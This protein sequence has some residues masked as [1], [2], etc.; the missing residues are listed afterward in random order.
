[1]TK[2]SVT[3]FLFFALG[4]VCIYSSRAYAFDFQYDMPQFRYGIHYTWNSGQWVEAARFTP[5]YNSSGQLDSALVEAY[6]NQNYIAY[7]RATETYVNGMISLYRISSFDGTSWSGLEVDSFTYSGNRILYQDRMFYK[8]GALQEH[9][10]YTHSYNGSGVRIERLQETLIPGPR[11]NDDDWVYVYDNQG[12]IDTLYDNNWD[13]AQWVR[14]AR[15]VYRY[16]TG[17]ELDSVIR[18]V[19]SAGAWSPYELFVVVGAVAPGSSHL[20]VQAAMSFDTLA[21]ALQTARLTL[22]NDGTAALNIPSFTLRNGTAFS[23]ADTAV[24]SI[25]AGGS[26]MIAVTFKP[27]ISGQYYDTL[28]IGP[29]DAPLA[30]VDLSGISRLANLEINRDT[31]SLSTIAGASDTAEVVLTNNANEV[32]SITTLRILT[33]PSDYSVEGLVDPLSIA[34][35]QSANL[36]VYYSPT[37][38][39]SL[40]SSATVSMS[41]T[42]GGSSRD[43]TFVLEGTVASSAVQRNEA[44]ATVLMLS[45][46]PAS[47]HIT[48]D[49]LS[50]I[51]EVHILD[52]AGQSVLSRSIT[53]PSASLDVSELASGVYAVQIL[54]TNGSPEIQRLAI[55]R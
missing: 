55:M 11:R 32:I 46:N 37:Q 14:K 38:S 36:S 12:R 1:M 5:S 50:G 34:A 28:V 13:G 31:T 9:D 25:A 16:G 30:T 22:T 23:L 45:P 6:V 52:A 24:G 2:K 4:L 27:K 20:T 17:G 19:Y 54:H 41:Y 43:T 3:F 29:S 39:S 42:D 15:E 7:Q 47:N 26:A 33:T 8:N 10:L 49:G 40:S 48:L 44:K 51:S 53:G 35:G 21:G 18:D